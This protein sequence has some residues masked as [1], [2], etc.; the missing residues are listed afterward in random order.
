MRNTKK[1][2]PLQSFYPSRNETEV[3]PVIASTSDQTIDPAKSNIIDNDEP[4]N[5]IEDILLNAIDTCSIVPFEIPSE[6]FHLN[7]FIL[8]IIKEFELWQC[9][10]Q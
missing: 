10:P 9:G 3:V 2:I 4:S 7:S 1:I 6:E 5:N 8:E